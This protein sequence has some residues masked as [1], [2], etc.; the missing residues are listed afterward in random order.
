MDKIKV[1]GVVD[2]SN[3][4]VGIYKS[5]E[6]IRNSARLRGENVENM[7]TVVFNVNYDD[8]PEPVFKFYDD[9]HNSYLLALNREVSQDAE[10]VQEIYKQL[11]KII[12]ENPMYAKGGITLE[13]LREWKYKEDFVR[14]LI[15]KG[16]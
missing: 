11:R 2:T 15:K 13:L 6:A 7:C 5:F 9:G 12:N 1:L 14:E 10:E 4:I 8:D 3:G 16:K